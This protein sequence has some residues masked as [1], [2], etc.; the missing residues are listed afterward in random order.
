M[1]NTY[2]W[3]IVALECYPQYEGKVNVVRTVHWR[4]LATDGAGHN[5]DIF[6]ALTVNF[7]PKSPFTP[8]VDLTT[9]AIC[10]WLEAELGSEVLAR[11]E[12]A[13][14]AQLAN[15]VSPLLASPALPWDK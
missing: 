1:A 13:L 8:Y 15:Q 7:D 12:A 10:G 6:G 3:V 2:E 14:D 5:A 11:Q 4:R 9:Q